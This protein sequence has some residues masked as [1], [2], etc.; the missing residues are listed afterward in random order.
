MKKAKKSSTSYS[1]FTDNISRYSLTFQAIEV[2]LESLFDLD[3]IDNRI[4][5]NV[6]SKFIF[7]VEVGVLWMLL[8]EDT[9][10][11][12]EILMFEVV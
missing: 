4:E 5:H 7:V 9:K 3:A 2:P 6:E 1:V 12:L 11:K 10:D 8:N